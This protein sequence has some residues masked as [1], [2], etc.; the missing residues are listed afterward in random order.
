MTFF[1]KGDAIEIGWEGRTVDGTI[2]LMSENQIS[3][4]IRF[5][6]ILGKHAGA[7]PIMLGDDGSYRSIIDGTEVTMRRKA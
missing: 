2:Y 6:A 1:R 3:G 5:E 4:L 7:M